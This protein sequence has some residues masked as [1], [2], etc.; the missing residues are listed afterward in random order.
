MTSI[1]LGLHMD[2]MQE[3]V[4]RLNELKVC[5]S[6]EFRWH[7]NDGTANCAQ[8]HNDTCQFQGNTCEEYVFINNWKVRK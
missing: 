3:A 1:D 8:D 4:S 6:C 2:C 5:G 7:S